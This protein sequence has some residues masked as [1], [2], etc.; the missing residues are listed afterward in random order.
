VVTDEAPELI[1][2]ARI[3]SRALSQ[4]AERTKERSQHI[5]RSLPFTSRGR[6][7]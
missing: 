3:V 7:G 4:S 5:V 6:L 1:L 2:S